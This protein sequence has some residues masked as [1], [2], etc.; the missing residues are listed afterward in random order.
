MIRTAVLTAIAIA[1][2]CSCDGQQS[3]LPKSGGRPYEVLV[4]GN[5]RQA[6]AHIDSVLSQDADGLPQAEPQFDVSVTDS[7][8]FN[9]TARL[10]RNIVIINIDSTLFTATRLRYEKN[11]WARPQMVVYVNSPSRSTMIADLQTAGRKLTSLLARAEINTEM[12]RLAQ[13]CNT[14]ARDTIRKMMGCS[15]R[16]PADMKAGKRGHNFTWY[17]NNAASGMQNICVYAYP[18]DR[19]SP[20]T[21]LAARDS[22]M[23]ANIPGERDGMY[24]HTA[25]A[26]VRC[27]TAREHGRDILVSRGLWEMHGDAMGGPFVSHS[28]LDSANR[29][30]IVAEAFVYA[31]EMK[32]R[33]LIRR[34]EAA[35]YT[36]TTEGEHRQRDINGK[37]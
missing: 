20:Q 18:A 35:L 24:M 8:H 28:I 3:M 36:L 17:S 33:N 23:R 25:A 9:Q 6:A 11:V 15:I 16:I 30:V 12:S 5:D 14:A 22:V 37:E 19:L 2:M 31:P 29:R 26:T 34:L 21:A 32:K 1:V 4:T 27:G 10:A 13:S 7:Q